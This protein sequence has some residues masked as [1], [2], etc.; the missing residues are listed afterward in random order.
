MSKKRERDINPHEHTGSNVKFCPSTVKQTQD[1]IERL[2][3]RPSL[4][5]EILALLQTAQPDGQGALRFS[6]SN[7]WL[8]VDKLREA[9]SLLRQCEKKLEPESDHMDT[10]SDDH[11]S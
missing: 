6:E 2:A 3:P 9:A 1:W 10:D 5:T 8:L 4:M 7:R 11:S